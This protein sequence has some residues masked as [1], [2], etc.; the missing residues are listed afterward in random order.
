MI[1]HEIFP[2]VYFCDI[3]FCE[4]I[5]KYLSDVLFMV[6]FALLLQKIGKAA[7]TAGSYFVSLWVQFE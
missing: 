6:A 7:G 1:I 2:I 5:I 3:L 4:V